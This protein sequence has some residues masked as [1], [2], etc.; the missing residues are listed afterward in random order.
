MVK[1]LELY[2]GLLPVCMCV[3]MC[4]GVYGR[5]QLEGLCNWCILSNW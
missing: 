5:V 4:M 1:M 2:W 3:C